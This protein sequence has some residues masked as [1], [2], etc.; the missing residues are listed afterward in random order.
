ML[1]HLGGNLLET[2]ALA[3]RG[4]EWKC[5]SPAFQEQSPHLLAGCL[6]SKETEL[7]AADEIVSRWQLFPVNS[8]LVLQPALYG[9]TSAWDLSRDGRMDTGVRVPFLGVWLLSS[10]W[11]LIFLWGSF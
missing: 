8:T 11:F 6:L 7:T 9:F 2:L 5:G 10:A 4:G 3:F 1:Q